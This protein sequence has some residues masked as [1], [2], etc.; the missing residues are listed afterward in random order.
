MGTLGYE[1][2]T[3]LGVK[4]GN[5]DRPVVA[6]VG[7]GGFL[8]TVGELATAAQHGIGVVTLLYNNGAFGAS[9]N[10]QRSR[11]GGR[12]VGTEL[13]NPDF[14]RLAE[15]F[16]VR[17]FRVTEPEAVPGALKRAIEDSGPTLVELVVS[18]GDMPM[19]IYGP[20]HPPLRRAP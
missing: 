19:E 13:H 2:P 14:V 20:L 9:N 15:S 10:D 11:Y 6:I 16:G 12:V 3:A 7:D 1:L 4:V 5:P 8:Y 17:A 18:T